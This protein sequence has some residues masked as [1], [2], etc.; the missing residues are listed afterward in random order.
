MEKCSC[1]EERKSCVRHTDLQKIEHICNGTKERD[2]CTCGGD[3][4]RCDFYPEMRYKKRSG[5]DVYYAHHQ[6]KYGTKIE[7]YELN[8]IKRYFPNA[9]IFNPSTDITTIGS[10]EEIMKECLETVDNSD[11]IVFSSMDGVIGKGVYTEVMEARKKG[12]L[13]LYINHNELDTIV[14]SIAIYENGKDNAS[15][16]IY[17]IVNC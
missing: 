13:I 2:L 6:W 3:Q 12:K 16:R 9:R 7:E 14:P 1:Y 11:I 5:Y 10:E 17:A 4:T 15:D 8:L